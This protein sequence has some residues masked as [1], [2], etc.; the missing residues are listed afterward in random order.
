LACAE[1]GVTNTQVA[2]DLRV[3]PNTVLG[4]NGGCNT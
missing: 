2:D 3:A 1:P 4:S